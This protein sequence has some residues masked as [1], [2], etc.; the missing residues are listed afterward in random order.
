MQQDLRKADKDS[1]T[2]SAQPKEKCSMRL[3]L[4]C[5]TITLWA[6]CEYSQILTSDVVHGHE[7]EDSPQTK[8]L[9]ELSQTL[10]AQNVL[11]LEHVLVSTL[12]K[13]IRIPV[14]DLSVGEHGWESRPGL[15][16][17]NWPDVGTARRPGRDLH[18]VDGARPQP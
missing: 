8:A 10:D 1:Q 7:A 3:F 6:R 5:W 4:C 15:G 2:S 13:T 18:T 16:D 14:F 11:F 17:P 12:W 9:G